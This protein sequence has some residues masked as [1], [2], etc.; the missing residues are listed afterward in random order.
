MT[1][2]P[3]RWEAA[4]DP[5]AARLRAQARAAAPR[6][7]RSKPNRWHVP[8]TPVQALKAIGLVVA[9]LVVLSW[10]GWV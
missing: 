6:I 7:A 2:G 10:L 4:R 3:N 8:F 9:A 1:R 5:H